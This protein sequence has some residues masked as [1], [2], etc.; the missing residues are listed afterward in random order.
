MKFSPS[1]ILIELNELVPELMGRFMSEGQLPN[2]KRFHDESLVYTTDA[3]ESGDN[4]NPWV[5]WVTLHSGLSFE[6]HGV[7]R[8]SDG[9]KLQ[10]P[11][12]WDSLSDAGYKSWICGSMNAR[13]DR[14]LNGFFLPD[15]WSAGLDPFPQGEFEVFC[16]FVAKNVQKHTDKNAGLSKKDAFQFLK[17]MLRHGLKMETM[18]WAASQILGERRRDIGWRRAAI[19]DKIQFDLFRWYYRKHNPDFATFFSNST[20]HF[21]H[22]F[23]RNM[24]PEHFDMKPKAKEQVE[25]KNAILY[26]Y[27]R[28]DDLMGR[29][30]NLAKPETT[31]ILA[32][33]LSQQPFLKNE[34]TGGKRYYHIHNAQKFAE[35][36]GVSG[37]FEYEPVMTV[38]FY[39][40]FEQ[41]ADAIVA[42][43]NVKAWK[44]GDQQAIKARRAGNDV[45]Y[46][47]RIH[48]QLDEN[49]MLVSEKTGESVP[50]KNV[51]Y[52]IDAVKSAHHHP[53][54]ILWV[55]GPDRTHR[56]HDEKI[57]LRSVTPAI[58]DMFDVPHPEGMTCPSFLAEEAAT[59]AQP[60]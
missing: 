4:L 25:R 21:Q 28:M 29:F 16:E 57:S 54:G 26:G 52:Q 53:D 15:P 14:P 1:V 48:D 10:A 44:L 23:W 3:D 40:R 7:F 11:C 18:T 38:Q 37:K 42:E 56:V 60:V 33:A 58:L 13:F 22:Q 36:L 47:C 5:Q 39:L 59:V 50:F 34:D 8:L 20:A 19:L 43:E 51:F 27:Q 12:V 32:T 17:F 9:H 31:L 24:E 45:F 35:K 46:Q 30:M 49:A 41:E 2:F 6:Q 55:R